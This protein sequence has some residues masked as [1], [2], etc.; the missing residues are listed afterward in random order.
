MSVLPP[1]AQSAVLRA[2]L[3]QYVMWREGYSVDTAKFRHDFVVALSSGTVGKQYTDWFNYPNPN[4]P[5]VWLGNNGTITIEQNYADFR[6]NDPHAYDVTYTRIVKQDG[7]PEQRGKF[8]ASVH[9]KQ[10]EWVPLKDRSTFNP[11]G[12]QVP[13]IRIPYTS[14]HPLNPA[15]G[16]APVIRLGGVCLAAL[17]FASAPAWTMTECKSQK[18]MDS[19]VCVVPYDE[20]QVVHVFIP[21]RSLVM[22]RFGEDE[23]DPRIMAADTSSITFVPDGNY[24]AI[25]PKAIV[26]KSQPI[27]ILTTN[28]KTGKVSAYPIQLDVYEGPIDEKDA[29]KQT[30]DEPRAQFMVRDTY[31]EQEVAAA[32]ERAKERAAAWQAKQ[33]AMQL[34]LATTAPVQNCSYVEQ[35]DPDHPLPFVPVSVCDDGQSTTMRFPGNMPVPSV[36]IEGPDGKEMAPMKSFNAGTGELTVH[37]VARHYFLRYG[38][39]LDCIWKIGPID[40]IG[41]NPGTGTISPDVQR[42]LRAPAR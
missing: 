20:K 5:Q 33:A 23:A 19:R 13:P 24:A 9:F 36:F 29:A 7:R 39:A 31:P 8:R 21:L 4:S 1:D 38:D 6:E 37:Q 35:H 17:L 18:G 30:P 41:T 16:E 26:W 28:K 12:V 3:W 42:V 2:T 14:T 15:A 27:T 32:R 25:K 10:V 22:F 34:A 11:A 40:P